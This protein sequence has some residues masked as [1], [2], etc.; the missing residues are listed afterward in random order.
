MREEGKGKNKRQEGEEEEKK[1]DKKSS[2]QNIR[3]KGGK[4]N[5]P[6]GRDIM[7]EEGTG[8]EETEGKGKEKDR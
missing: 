4:G 8:R 3:G 6:Q 2:R 5:T 1:K 7:G